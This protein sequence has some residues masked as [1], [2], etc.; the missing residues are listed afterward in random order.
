MSSPAAEWLSHFFLAADF[1]V[2]VPLFLSD[3][4]PAF[5]AAA[6]FLFASVFALILACSS[7]YLLFLAIFASILF[8]CFITLPL[9]MTSVSFGLFGSPPVFELG[10]TVAGPIVVLLD[11]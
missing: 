6:A 10:F 8:T 5:L 11:V 4:F 7:F 2:N 3:F 9:G 1:G